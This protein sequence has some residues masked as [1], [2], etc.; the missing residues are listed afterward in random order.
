MTLQPLSGLPIERQRYIRSPGSA[1]W[2]RRN[3]DA[4]AQGFKR[5]TGSIRQHTAKQDHLGISCHPQVNSCVILEDSYNAALETAF[6]TTGF[7][8]HFQMHTGALEI[9]STTDKD[10]LLLRWGGETD[11]DGCVEVYLRMTAP[12]AMAVVAF[13][14]YTGGSATATATISGGIPDPDETMLVKVDVVGLD[15]TLSVVRASGTSTGLA[16]LINKTVTAGMFRELTLFSAPIHGVLREP[17]GNPAPKGPRPTLCDVGVWTVPESSITGT[18]SR[19][20]RVTAAQAADPDMIVYLPFTDGAYGTTAET[21]SDGIAMLTPAAPVIDATDGA[22]F[23]GNGGFVRIP[24]NPTLDQFFTRKVE[25]SKQNEWS[26]SMLIKT[27]AVM[28]FPNR[29]DALLVDIG[30][31]GLLLRLELTKGASWFAK[32]TI[33][34]GG[35]TA[36]VTST[37]A[38]SAGTAYQITVSR[39]D[40]ALRIVVNTTATDSGTALVGNGPTITEGDLPEIIVGARYDTT[41]S[42]TPEVWSENFRGFVKAI[43]MWPYAVPFTNHATDG[44]LAAPKDDAVFYHDFRLAQGDQSTDQGPNGLTAFFQVEDRSGTQSAPPFW[45]SGPIADDGYKMCHT[46]L[47]FLAGRIDITD[48]THGKATNQFR[49]YQSR[50]FGTDISAAR[51]GRKLIVVSG[52]RA[53]LIDE[54][55]RRIRPLGLPEP[56]ARPGIIQTA[57]GPISGA[58]SY[59]YSFV[60][61]DGTESPLKVLPAITAKNATLAIGAGAAALGNAYGTGAGSDYWKLKDPLAA[62]AFTEI[63]S[64]GAYSMECFARLDT[65][66]TGS[67][68]RER[69]FDRGVKLEDETSTVFW[70]R[71]EQSNGGAIDASEPWTLQVSFKYA[72]A[73]NANGTVIAALGLINRDNGQSDH[74][75]PIVIVIK[76]DHTIHVRKSAA[77]KIQNGWAA[78]F[79][80]TTVYTVGDHLNVVATYDGTNYALYVN[81][82]ADAGSSTAGVNG[83]QVSLVR[84]GLGAGYSRAEPVDSGA[85]GYLGNPLGASIKA[86]D[87]WEWNGCRFW[88]RA[89]PPSQVAILDNA[90]FD[91]IEHSALADGLQRDWLFAMDDP[92]GKQNTY[93]DRVANDPMSFLKTQGAAGSPPE[94]AEGSQVWDPEGANMAGFGKIHEDANGAGMILSAIRASGA[95]WETSALQVMWSRIGNGSLFAH[96]GENLVYYAANDAMHANTPT[97]PTDPQAWAW[98]SWTLEAGGGTSPTWTISSFWVNGVRRFSG[99]SQVSKDKTRDTTYTAHLCGGVDAQANAFT[100]HLGE[101]RVWDTEK[102]SKGSDFLWLTRRIEAS[103]FDELIY[104]YRMTEQEVS[105]AIANDGSSGTAYDLEP[106]DS[107]G[108]TTVSSLPLPVPPIPDVVALRFYRSVALPVSD[109]NDNFETD[110]LKRASQGGPFF[111]VG[112]APAGVA[113]FQDQTPNESLGVV[114]RKTGGFVPRYVSGVATWNGVPVLWTGSDLN[115]WVSDPLDFESYEDDGRIEVPAS[116][117]HAVVAAVQAGSAFYVFGNNGGVR[118]RG[119]PQ[120]YAQ[121]VSVGGGVGCASANC[122]AS[123]GGFVYVYGVAGLWVLGDGERGPVRKRLDLPI[124]DLTPSVSA[125]RL[126]IVGDSLY[127]IDTSDGSALRFHLGLQAWVGVEDRHVRGGTMRGNETYWVHTSGHLA[128]NDASTY[129]DDVAAGWTLNGTVTSGGATTLSDSG[130]PWTIDQLIGAWIRLIRA[131]D[132]STEYRKIN[133]NTTS[134]VTVDAWSGAAPTSGDT[135]ALGA[136]E[137]L[138]DTGWMMAPGQQLSA[139]KQSIMRHSSAFW[140]VGHA[141]ANDI[142]A[143]SADTALVYDTLAAS[144]DIGHLQSHEFVRLALRHLHPEAAE[145]SLWWADLMLQTA[146]TPTSA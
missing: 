37:A 145:G 86:D 127:L 96:S 116:D 135:Y 101:F 56:T 46:G 24:W 15:V 141:S 19:A 40:G 23:S 143:P 5:R 54:A 18:L 20:T 92:F 78:A 33:G 27:P 50:A 133:D 79:T 136:F 51:V 25:A 22:R 52:N 109:F 81:G 94:V 106:Q 62:D 3:V 93:D 128:I 132:G 110:R 108:F 118:Y 12:T 71:S 34:H 38:L 26:V 28:D 7:L 112:S 64:G 44:I 59:A 102:Y 29:A 75:I 32:A 97:L 14:D 69:V 13:F 121:P 87:D 137:C 55:A 115:L 53:H 74:A 10:L 47:A 42:A 119:S 30:P 120:Q 66:L 6:T 85:D 82:A 4:L 11:A 36:S 138:Q 114:A 60:S 76:S 41:E 80:G 57:P 117:F 111:F 100:T 9:D 125:A 113:S 61:K 129:A 98:Y 49:G 21:A 104:Y 58:L 105:E 84:I 107:P 48:P 72:T 45:T 68:L 88:Q 43:G 99:G 77:N 89:L 31:D 126:Q 134:Q 124:H 83:S 8:V 17:T 95:S 16:T 131:S 103:D 65:T 130:A 140:E 35:G 2:K 39:E 1:L 146:E 70:G 123:E 139:R 67:D 90:W 73:G 122:I 63:V 91:P 142:G 144:G